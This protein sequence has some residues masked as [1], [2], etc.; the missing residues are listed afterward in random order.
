VHTEYHQNLET[1][2]AGYKNILSILSFLIYRQ[3]ELPIRNL[4]VCCVWN[5]QYLLSAGPITAPLITIVKVFSGE[6]S[7]LR[8]NVMLRTLIIPSHLEISVVTNGNCSHKVIQN[9]FFS[10]TIPFYPEQHLPR[11]VM[12]TWNRRNILLQWGQVMSVQKFN[13]GVCPRTSGTFCFVL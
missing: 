9:I 11:N 7:F 10:P 6:L 4:C 8:T 12:E 1:N 2:S 13:V 5:R 3:R